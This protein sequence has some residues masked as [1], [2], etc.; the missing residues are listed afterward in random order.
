M[1]KCIYCGENAGFL[2][3]KHNEC[4]LKFHQGQNEY[5]EAIKLCIID[6]FNFNEVKV[7]LEKIQQS[8]YITSNLVNNLVTKA[9]DLAIEH[10]LEDGILSLDEEEKIS[11]FK[12]EFDISQE[13]LDRNGSYSKVGMSL[14]LRDLTEGKN[15]KERINIDGHLPFLFQKSE[16]IVWL[17]KNVEF[18]EQQIR[19][20]YQGGSQGISVRVAKG[21]YYRASAFKGRPVKI[22][23]MKYIGTGLLVL[24]TKHIYFGSPEKKIKI[25]LNKL[26][27]IEPYEDGIGIQKDGV[28]AKP[29][30]FKN[31]DGWFMHNAISNLTQ[32]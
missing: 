10:F 1:G 32:A 27:S 17:F 25:P 22:S 31:I 2:K 6:E 30:V 24:T 5:I 13:I 4:E 20:E 7:K 26:I 16:T 3:K 15:P 21:V 8:S 18:Y 14:I 29:Q 11:K 28:T 9:F 12:E 19:T 23:E